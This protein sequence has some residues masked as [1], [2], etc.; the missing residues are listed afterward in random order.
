MNSPNRHMSYRRSVYRKNRIKTVIVSCLCT[1]LTLTV[2][3]VIVGNI[4]MSRADNG[5]D[6]PTPDDGSGEQGSHAEVRT[7]YACPVA[8]AADG[9]TLNSRLVS[10]TAKGFSEVCFDLDT[11]SGALYYKSATAAALGKQRDAASDLR[12]LSNIVNLV[13]AN[14][15]YASGITH[16]SDFSSS[17]DLVR[18][19]AV[20]YHAALI[21]EALRAGLGDVLVCPGAIDEARYA[22]LVRLADEVHRLVP[23]ARI[24]IALPASV[25]ASENASTVVDSLWNAYDYLALDLEGSTDVDADMGSILYYL[26][27]FN[28]RVL[29]PASGGESMAQRLRTDYSAKNIQIM[30]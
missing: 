20:G 28:V 14:G 25:Y 6:A 16:I 30:P 15:L 26:L 1:V 17:D 8:L 27:R 29:V 11:P 10:A 3:F 13:S 18:S 22:E 4:L 9:S 12:S 19:A 5:T 7:V 24:G 23:D 2:A 21:A